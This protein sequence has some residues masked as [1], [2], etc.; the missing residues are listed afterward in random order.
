MIYPAATH[1]YMNSSWHGSM[2]NDAIRRTD[3]YW[4]GL[5][6]DLV[7]EHAMMKSV[8]VRGGLTR[9]R[10]MHETVR[11][12]WVNT[13]SE[14]AT[15][16]M[17]MSAMTGLGLKTNDHVGIGKSGVHRDWFD[18][19]KIVDYFA[20][21]S[22]FRFCDPPKLISL[23]SGVVAGADDDVT[24]DTAEDVAV[25]FRRNGMSYHICN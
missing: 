19:Q 10:G 18:R 20:D 15:V 21:K 14:C 13:M 2:R 22:P 9:G 25:E 17:V 5:S 16:H 8:K 1:F 7:T 6:S 12:S 3:K 4:S 24:C 23:S 11:A